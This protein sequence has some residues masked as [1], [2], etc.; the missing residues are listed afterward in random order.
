[1]GDSVIQRTFAGGELAP[2]LTARADLV[3]Y[4][5]GL[6]RCRNF[7]VLRSGGVANRAGTRFVAECKTSS[8]AVQLHRF[9]S[10]VAGE[11]LLLEAGS[12]YIRFFKNG[13]PVTVSAVP[14]Y[15]GATQYVIG[16][17]VSDAG[18]NYYCVQ[19]TI[20]N[21]PPN[22]TFWYAMPSNLLE[23]P[24]P[25]SSTGWMGVQSGNVITMTA[26]S[27]NVAPYELIY[28]S[29]TSWVIRRID[30]KP[31]IDA[32]TGVVGTATATPGTL[33]FAYQVTAGAA[34][35]YE[36]S[37]S[38][39]VASVPLTSEATIEEPVQLTWTPVP[40]AAEYY[41]YKDPYG[42]G[43]FGFIGT[44]TCTDAV[45]GTPSL[46]ND[47]G[48][49]PDLAVTPPLPRDLFNT[50]GEHP[51]VSGF[52]QQRRLLANTDN[53]PDAAYG[54]RTGFIRN[55]SVSSPL[56][57]DDAIS[58]KIAGNQHNPIRHLLGLKTL[59]MM[60]DA[61]AW[62][63]GQRLVPLTPSNLPADQEAYS[64]VAAWPPPVIVGNAAIYVQARGTILRDLQFDQ[65]VEGLAGRDLTIFASH[66]FDGYTI[67]SLAFQEV[68]HSTV[69]ACRSDGTLLGLTYLREQ[70]MWGWHRHDTVAEGRFEHVQVVPES[71]EDVLYVL[72]RR[73]IGGVFHR[74][75]EKLES[76]EI[77]TYDVDAFFVDCGLSYSGAPATVFS[78][79]GHLEGQ[80]VAVLAD[81]VV[82]SNGWDETTSLQVVS[83][84][85]T[86][87]TAAT[88]V[89]IGLPITHPEIETLNLDVQGSMIRDRRKR[90]GSVTLLVDKTTR[91]VYL[92]PDSNNLTPY[93]STP[94]EG[95]A[96]EFTGEIEQMIVTE[97]NPHGRV[98]LQLRDPVPVTILGILPNL[99]LG[100]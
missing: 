45:A 14:A 25:F 98:F 5:T 63:V 97:Y 50:A 4:T 20:G 64:G 28:A 32:P 96:E 76:R 72:T 51:R 78:G 8:I 2:A 58:F 47:A 81:G 37:L 100:G 85:V 99:E 1:M 71:N 29:L 83:G 53:N 57:D 95:D 46:F 44:T 52:H 13:G 43:T 65:Q 62:N 69:W 30:T 91:E 22:A 40:G 87:P 39:G 55:F 15:S 11:S 86:I 88:N 60:T 26:R 92:G 6:R 89:H 93:K 23:L 56:Q 79:L 19:D 61:G 10:A 75:I 34:D 82:V 77:L 27:G 7:L 54:S 74:Y 66:L 67:D 90:V 48:F 3:K 36:E 12:G 24:S 94:W 59:I 84:A 35:S 80:F 73:T 21:A 41:I 68:P 49:S 33:T 70:E 9:I 17:L 31:S 38:S 42:N 16:D 18:V